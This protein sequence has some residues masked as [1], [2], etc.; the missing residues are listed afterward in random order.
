MSKQRITM[1]RISHTDKG[2]VS[3]GN[4][5]HHEKFCHIGQEAGGDVRRCD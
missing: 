3:Y 5:K 2:G 1:F 4:F